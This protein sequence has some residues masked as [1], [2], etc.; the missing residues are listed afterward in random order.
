MSDVRDAALSPALAAANSC[1]ANLHFMPN[2]TIGE[3]H[4]PLAWVT[5]RK[6]YRCLEESIIESERGVECHASSNDGTVSFDNNPICH[7]GFRR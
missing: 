2:I 7:A 3:Y 1:V 4:H 5:E 6:V